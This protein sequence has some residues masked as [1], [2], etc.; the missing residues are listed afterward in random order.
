MERQLE[1]AVSPRGVASSQRTAHI[2]DAQLHDL[3][4]A[5]LQTNSHSLYLPKI[6]IFVSQMAPLGP[7]QIHSLTPSTPRAPNG[8]STKPVPVTKTID[9]TVFAELFAGTVTIFVLAVLFWKVGK[10]IRSFNRHKVL[11]EGKSPKMRYARTWYGWVSLETHERNKEIFGKALRKLR[12]WTAW[13]STRTDYRWVWWDPGQK[14]LEER[15]RNGRLFKWLPEC[16]QS[17]DFMTAD[18]IWNPGPPVQCHGA[19]CNLNPDP[20]RAADTLR[21]RKHNTIALPGEDPNAYGQRVDASFTTTEADHL[22]RLPGNELSV[23][24][25]QNDPLSNA[26]L[27]MNFSETPNSVRSLPISR[28]NQV[29][30]QRPS[31]SRLKIA[32]SRYYSEFS[33]RSSNLRISESR[34]SEKVQHV[35]RDP[36]A[37]YNSIPTRCGNS[38][39][40]RVWSAQMQ[41]RGKRPALLDLRDSSGP[42]GT[43]MT[44]ILPS[45]I[46]AQSPFGSELGQ[47][48][49]GD[50]RLTKSPIGRLKV[51]L[52]HSQ[53]TA[54][55][56]DEGSNVVLAEYGKAK[57]N[58]VPLQSHTAAAKNSKVPWQPK[59]AS[60]LSP[61]LKITSRRRQPVYDIWTVS[62]NTR[63]RTHASQNTDGQ[64]L[65]PTRKPVDGLSD[66][67]VRL[68][69]G[70]DRKLVWMFNELTPG[71]KPYHFA[72]LANHWL[73]KET[74]LVIDP[75][76]RVS[77]D[78][79]RQWGDPRFNVPYPESSVTARPKYPAAMRKRAHTPHIDSWRAAVNKQRKVS[80]LHEVVRAVELFEG[81]AEEP[82]DGK[83]DP[84][85]WLLPKP[86]QGYEMS[87]NQKNA[88]YEGGAG[89]QEKLEDWQKVGR[90]YLLQKAL[91]EGR[92][93]RNHVKGVATQVGRCCRSASVKVIPRKIEQTLSPPVS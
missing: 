84:A 4:N 91:H 22:Q 59:Q 12:E 6:P 85:S 17:Y 88:W 27:L 48:Y 23:G 60:P 41:V 28:K 80:G 21:R 51:A 44:S 83:I 90:G 45:H 49:Q 93:N 9:S 65:E 25:G 10:F 33:A 38:L 92:V 42:P 14:A 2:I 74:W 8:P 43:P 78:R 50:G 18:E 46:S 53:A 55:K 29:S 63:P 71:Q 32:R 69:D 19:L 64:S 7:R 26:R 15:R 54:A 58:T 82:P 11:G 79:R 20:P 67:E 75:V 68:M 5:Q 24:H 73:N 1:G 61:A 40:Y 3:Q 34:R 62:E 52:R 70:L 77:T 86:P 66:W 89:W 47:Q 81:S 37:R 87:T 56:K 30:V 31:V 57:Y 36:T 16:F 39:R 72:M 35:P 76:S 13:K